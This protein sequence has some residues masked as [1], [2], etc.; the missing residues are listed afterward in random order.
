MNQDSNENIEMESDSEEPMD[1]RANNKMQMI[2]NSDDEEQLEIEDED[3]PAYGDDNQMQLVPDL[4]AAAQEMGLD[5]NPSQIKLL[6]QHIADQQNGEGE[7]EE[8][9]NWPGSESQMSEDQEEEVNE[10]QQQILMQDGEEEL[11]DQGE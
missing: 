1:N 8:N 7:M 4:M 10:D 6:Q 11:E 3:A 5:L 2:E 9:P